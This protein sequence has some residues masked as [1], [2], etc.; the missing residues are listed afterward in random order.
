MKNGF[1][2]VV[3]ILSGKPALKKPSFLRQPESRNSLEGDG[4]VIGF[5]HI[6]RFQFAPGKEIL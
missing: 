1:S 2:T 4:P 6:K 3:F 5:A